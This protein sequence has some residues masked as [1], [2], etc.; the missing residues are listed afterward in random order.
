MIN[1]N[2]N[3]RDL[4][5]FRV[6]LGSITGSKVGDLMKSGK[7]KEQVFGDTALSYIY[8]VAAERMLNPVFVDDDELFAD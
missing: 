2:E 3:Q 7:K 1:D 4:G 5:W 8:Q 6:R